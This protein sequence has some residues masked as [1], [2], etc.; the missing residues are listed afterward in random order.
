M[1]IGLILGVVVA[2]VATTARAEVTRITSDGTVHRIDVDAWSPSGRITGTALKWTRQFPK[3]GKESSYIPGTDDAAPDR[4]PAV[5]IDPAT[6][7]VVVV[8]ARNE[9]AGFNIFASRYDGSW[10][11]PRLLA[12]M[13][14]DEL[15]PQLRIGP[16]ALHVSWRQDVSGQ[17]SWWRSSFRADTFEPVFGPERLPT[18]DATAVPPDGGPAYG[19]TEAPAGD[20]YFSATVFGRSPGDPGRAYVWGVRD[21]PVPFNF[22]QCL[23]LPAEVRSVVAQDARFIFGRFTYWFTTADRLYYTTLCN[24]RWAEMRVVELNASTSSADAQLMIRELF[25]RLAGGGL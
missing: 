19:T 5:E 4:D 22:R 10:S 2:V 8:W 23:T 7:A 6:G 3:G 20:L 16:K 15:E 18:D 9:G 25:K 1:R 21:E 12:R 14:G 17:T 13:D 11:L 24:G